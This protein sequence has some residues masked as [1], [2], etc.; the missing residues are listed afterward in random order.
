[1]KEGRTRLE[2]KIHTNLAVTRRSLDKHKPTINDKVSR[3]VVSD[4]LNY[5]I[6]LFR[7]FVTVRIST[8]R[9]TELLATVC[10]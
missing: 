10:Q 1:M 9:D 7:N 2:S 8:V 3:N 5:T 6:I 4:K